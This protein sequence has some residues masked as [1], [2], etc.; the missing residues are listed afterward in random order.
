MGDTVIGSVPGGDIYDAYLEVCKER[1]SLRKEVEFEKDQVRLTEQAIKGQAELM[2]KMA[3]G[4]K[5]I[6]MGLHPY[7]NMELGEDVNNMQ[8]IARTLIK[9]YNEFKQKNETKGE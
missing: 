3:E 6:A 5:S 1:D 2:D 7:V 9:Q 4:L 8:G